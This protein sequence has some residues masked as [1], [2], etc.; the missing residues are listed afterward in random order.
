MKKINFNQNL[1]QIDAIN[2]KINIL[3]AKNNATQKL[4]LLNH[5]TLAEDEG[6]LFTKRR[7]FHTFGM[8][9]PICVL[10]FNKGKELI[11]KPTLVA[12]NRVFVCPLK[13]NYVA[14]VHEIHQNL[15]QE[16]KTTNKIHVLNRS[17]SKVI[18]YLCKL[19]P[20]LIVLCSLFITFCNAFALSTIN[21]NLGK[22][23]T[24]NLEQALRAFK[25]MTRRL[26]NL[27]VLVSQIQSKLFLNNLVKPR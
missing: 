20:I 19:L 15:Y 18:F 2:T 11:A 1:E 4:G 8:R 17:K 16:F 27:S 12:P 3:H 10:A 9:F 6:I 14:E 24:I 21:L 26:S 7:L 13:S 25:L 23:R 22:T 5:R